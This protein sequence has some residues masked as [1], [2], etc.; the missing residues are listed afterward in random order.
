MMFSHTDDVYLSSFGARLAAT[1][2]VGVAAA[3][4]RRAAHG[5]ATLPPIARQR[6]IPTATGGSWTS[7]ADSSGCRLWELSRSRPSARIEWPFYTQRGGPPSSSAPPGTCER[8]SAGDTHYDAASTGRGGGDWRCDDPRSGG[9]ALPLSS[10]AG[11]SGARAPLEPRARGSIGARTGPSPR[12]TLVTIPDA[13]SPPSRH[14]R[15]AVSG[16]DHGGRRCV[17]APRGG[18]APWQWERNARRMHRGCPLWRLVSQVSPSDGRPP[19][20][21][22]YRPA[23]VKQE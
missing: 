7:A 19:Q 6:E 22:R 15:R 18:V 12:R 11:Y 1:S 5:A 21:W 17:A 14:G 23:R 13:T 4:A 3:T 16:H 10:A 20:P 8:R 9:D 2:L